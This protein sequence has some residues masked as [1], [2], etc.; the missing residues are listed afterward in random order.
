MRDKIEIVDVA[1]GEILD[2][3]IIDNVVKKEWA[4]KYKRVIWLYENNP[5]AM[6]QDEIEFLCLKVYKRS[7][8]VNLNFKKHKK[9]ENNNEGFCTIKIDKN[10]VKELNFMTRG[11]LYSI[12]PLLSES[13]KIT[14]GNGIPINSISKLCKEIGM[15]Y[16]MYKRKV[17]KD[18]DKH[19]IIKRNKIGGKNYLV[20]NPLFV[21]RYLNITEDLFLTFH[22]ELKQHLHPIDYFMLCGRWG[23]K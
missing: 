13:N 7:E 10:M 9:H 1:T 14:Y 11:L 16:D 23:I 22:K 8:R 15:S 17:K 12:T 3:E 20:L 19:C 4:Q 6:T 21:T 5:S 18:I 2:K